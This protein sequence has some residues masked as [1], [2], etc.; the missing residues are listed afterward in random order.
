MS[1]IQFLVIG[2]LHSPSCLF[3]PSSHGYLLEWK[4]ISTVVVGSVNKI[5]MFSFRCCLAIVIWHAVYS[6]MDNYTS[7]ASCYNFLPPIVVMMNDCMM[8]SGLCWVH[9]G[10]VVSLYALIGQKMF[11]FYT[12]HCALAWGKGWQNWWGLKEIQHDGCLAW[13]SYKTESL[14]LIQ[15]DLYLSTLQATIYTYKLFYKTKCRLTTRLVHSSHCAVCPSTTLTSFVGL[16]PPP[17]PTPP[18]K[19]I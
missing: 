13:V 19:G 14:S 6:Y 18:R 1:G 4:I 5:C 15:L 2:K 3:S 9:L 7:E 8:W 11:Y 16:Q 10:F 12:W 17:H